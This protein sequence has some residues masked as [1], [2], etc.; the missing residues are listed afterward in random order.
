M[1]R[2]P[3]TPAALPAPT[4]PAP[5]LADLLLGKGLP[6]EVDGVQF[7]LRQPTTEEYDDAMML[8][9]LVRT[10]FLASPEMVELRR[11]P[12]SD[13][14][15]ALVGELREKAKKAATQEE[16]IQLIRQAEE[17]GKRT[18]A[19]EL[20]GRQ[21]SLKRDRYLTARLLC[22][23]DGKALCDTTTPEGVEAWERVPLRVKEAA[24]PVIWKMITV[25]ESLPFGWERQ[26][27]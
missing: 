6:F 1:P 14:L 9:D 21:A 20:A 24:R 12:A 18:L 11:Q 27:S 26:R 4:E 10:S 7:Y 16:K 23:A 5:T 19:D 2:L 8:A 13:E 15:L 25:M 3:Q 17:L 22:D